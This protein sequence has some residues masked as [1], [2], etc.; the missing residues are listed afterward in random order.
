MM[1]DIDTQLEDP[2]VPE[3]IKSVKETIKKLEWDE[4]ESLALPLVDIFV[5]II[6]KWIISK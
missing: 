2:K 4:I 1:I 6:V 3:L 5:E